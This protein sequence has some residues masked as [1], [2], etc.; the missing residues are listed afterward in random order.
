M[1]IGVGLEKLAMKGLGCRLGFENVYSYLSVLSYY[2]VRESR[3]W[4]LGQLHGK[5]RSRK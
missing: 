4:V 5:V 3:V 2:M 1:R